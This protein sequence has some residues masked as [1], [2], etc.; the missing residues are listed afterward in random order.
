MSFNKSQG[1][2][3]LSFFSAIA[4]F[5]I[6]AIELFKTSQFRGPL[7]SADSTL[8][9]ISTFTLTDRLIALREGEEIDCFG[10]DFLVAGAFWLCSLDLFL[11]ACGDG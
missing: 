1:N 3:P 5:D 4:Y 6:S 2:F 8:N 7:Y 10:I 11:H 9:T